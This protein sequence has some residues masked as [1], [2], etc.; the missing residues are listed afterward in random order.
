MIS[1]DG[2]LFGKVSIID[3]LAVLAILVIGFGIYTKFFVGNEK[4]ATTSTQFEYKMK[5]SDVR[6]GTVDALKNY[7][8]DIYDTTTK[9]YLGKIVNVE[10]ADAIKAAELSNGQLVESISPQR[11][12]VTVT[13]RVDGNINNSGYYT[14]NNQSICAGASHVFDAKAARTTGVILDVY[15]VQ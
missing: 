2:K 7:G 12:D 10:Y 8:G 11:Y 3:I 9:E 4:I 5:V 14:A 15:E 13:V 6:I 1:K